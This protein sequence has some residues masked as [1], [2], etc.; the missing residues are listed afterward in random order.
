M[1]GIGLESKRDLML[2]YIQCIFGNGLRLNP[3]AIVH[4]YIIILTCLI[5]Q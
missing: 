4:L 3:L 5:T 1:G 2:R